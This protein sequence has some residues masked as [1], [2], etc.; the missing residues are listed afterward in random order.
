[1]RRIVDFNKTDSKPSWEWISW[2]WLR[3]AITE[4]DVTRSKPYGLRLKTEKTC[5]NCPVSL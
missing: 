4:K 5:L 1:M 2:K 3:G